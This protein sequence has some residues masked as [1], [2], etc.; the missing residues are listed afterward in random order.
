MGIFFF[1]IKWL[2][3]LVTHIVRMQLVHK[4]WLKE[5]DRNGK[6]SPRVS[7]ICSSIQPCFVGGQAG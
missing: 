4:W 7:R 1:A 3:I 2:G 5:R 6:M